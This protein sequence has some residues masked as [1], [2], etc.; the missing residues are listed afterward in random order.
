MI[1]EFRGPTRWL[2]NFASVT[3]KYRGYSYLNTEAAYQA[4]KA[5]APSEKKLFPTLS[6]ADAK[7]K[8]MEVKLRP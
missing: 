6:P 7:K 5:M 2:S 4:Q 8:G 3:I 1:G